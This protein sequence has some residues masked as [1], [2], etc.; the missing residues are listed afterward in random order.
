MTLELLIGSP[1]SWKPSKMSQFLSESS[2]Y[3]KEAGACKYFKKT[4]DAAGADARLWEPYQNWGDLLGKEHYLI[5][6]SFAIQKTGHVNTRSVTELLNL[7]RNKY[8]HTKE[9]TDEQRQ[10]L[11]WFEKTDDGW[12]FVERYWAQYW[13]SRFPKLLSFLWATFAEVRQGGKLQKFYPAY[14]EPYSGIQRVT[15]KL[16]REQLDTA[17]SYQRNQ[18][19]YLKALIF[20]I[21]I[22]PFLIIM[23]VGNLVARFTSTG[24]DPTSAPL[25]LEFLTLSSK[26]LSEFL[27]KSS[28]LE[29]SVLQNVISFTWDGGV[30]NQMTNYELDQLA[31]CQ[32][33]KKILVCSSLSDIADPVTTATF[34]KKISPGQCKKT[35]LFIIS[36]HAEKEGIQGIVDR[37]QKE[38]S[39]KLNEKCL[40]WNELN[41]STKTSVLQQS[42]LVL[43]FDGMP[44]EKT[45]MLKD[46]VS[47]K[48]QAQSPLLSKLEGDILTQ[49]LMNKR[50]VIFGK[51]EVPTLPPYY[52]QH[53]LQRK[54]TDPTPANQQR[55]PV[56]DVV[57][58]INF[59][60]EVRNY[61]ENK[62]YENLK[63]SQL[64][65]L[66]ADIE[67]NPKCQIFV[68]E[69]VTNV[70]EVLATLKPK[71]TQHLFLFE[72]TGGLC[73]Q[74]I[75]LNSSSKVVLRTNIN[76]IVQSL[77]RREIR[78]PNE[79]VLV[80]S[81]HPRTGKSLKLKSIAA[82]SISSCE[83]G[84]RLIIQTTASELYVLLCEQTD[85][86][87]WFAEEEKQY[88][89][90]PVLCDLL[91]SSQFEKE[92]LK[93]LLENHTR[94]ELFLDGADE[95]IGER[96]A[97]S[98]LLGALKS[99]PP[100]KCIRCWFACNK[101]RFDK[102]LVGKLPCLEY[103]IQPYTKTDQINLLV[104]YWQWK[105]NSKTV[106]KPV[107]SSAALRRFAKKCLKSDAE[108]CSSPLQLHRLGEKMEEQVL[109]G[110]L[111]NIEM[112]GSLDLANRSFT[113]MMTMLKS[114]ICSDSATSNHMQDLLVDLMLTT[115]T[116]FAI[117]L[118]FGNKYAEKFRTRLT[119]DRPC[120][121]KFCAG[122]VDSG[123][124]LSVEPE[125]TFAH[126]NF[127]EVFVT[128]FVVHVLLSTEKN[129]FAALIPRE[130]PDF[131]ELLENEMFLAAPE[132]ELDEEQL[133]F[134][135]NVK[136]YELLFLMNAWAK[137][138]IDLA[139]NS[140]SPALKTIYT[141]ISLKLDTDS[142]NYDIPTLQACAPVF[143]Q[144]FKENF[145]GLLCVLLLSENQ[146][147]GMFHGCVS[148]HWLAEAKSFILGN[149]GVEPAKWAELRSSTSQKYGILHMLINGLAVVD[150]F[151]SDPEGDKLLEFAAFVL[152]QDP[153]Q[154][155]VRD[156]NGNTPLLFLF[157]IF[158]A[159]DYCDVGKRFLDWLL[160]AGAN[161]NAVDSQNN[162][163]LHVDSA[164]YE[165]QKDNEFLCEWAENYFDYL[166][167]WAN[168]LEASKVNDCAII[169]VVNV[170]G[171]TPLLS[172][173]RFF[174]EFMLEL[175]GVQVF[176]LLGSDFNARDKDG[177]SALHIAI[178]K[179][180]EVDFVKELIEAGADPRICNG[181]G[182]NVLHLAERQQNV[183]LV[184]L[185]TK[186]YKMGS[187]ARDCK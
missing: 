15:P 139:L 63:L 125:I 122:L 97:R 152:E 147:R 100:L 145:Q 56:R 83:T 169:N 36:K 34:F 19:N 9:F 1:L 58:L 114:S 172:A 161:V 101:T 180:F 165:V 132:T 127:A 107:P 128:D 140:M 183:E 31:P 8:V 25:T 37:A 151:E 72:S 73:Y 81:D 90:I 21:D 22:I 116:F 185:L 40:N 20:S 138:H 123:I 85:P 170:D 79:P 30:S 179:E 153:G 18:G 148:S 124:I 91:C 110:K 102:Q 108:L 115:V 168:E 149:V 174:G 38:L 41:S 187:G 154:L 57:I 160:D 158:F 80:I 17:L 67:S 175:E 106:V 112:D 135:S 143:A 48:K 35:E 55:E 103:S 136:H 113:S 7:I 6:V 5:L 92:V 159:Y 29:I 142:A 68:I 82:Q 166:E 12:V 171:D 177:N 14:L 178:G 186:T 93:I 162:T 88:A 155:E 182:M 71:E 24:L 27:D 181:E 118:L 167:M 60:P 87:N 176:K 62:P 49:L 126:R 150:S 78:F 33:L 65:D 141:A 75:L 53:G 51:G 74:K 16:F 111:K 96:A 109:T 77:G 84:D 70:A 10:K 105:L 2:D 3:L 28:R 45:V 4:L 69:K 50:A 104:A 157:K 94:V 32:N 54:N 164:E 129:V 59:P 173:V 76:E 52:V 89:M 43:Q 95:V 137:N 117:K 13:T 23:L 144:V 64:Y 44:W 119:D 61:F 39:T 184:E 134:D 66:T 86:K 11:G 121:G 26:A 156:V 133:F 120:F 163:I 131:Q 98:M 130:D 146:R 42:K 99:L 46:L 47:P